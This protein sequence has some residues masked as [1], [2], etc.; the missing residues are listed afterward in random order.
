M[1]ITK[2]SSL[3]KPSLEIVVNMGLDSNIWAPWD[4]SRMTGF[5]RLLKVRET[6]KKNQYSFEVSPSTGLHV[7]GGDNP[8]AIWGTF[9]ALTPGQFLVWWGR[10]NPWRSPVQCAEQ[11][12]HKKM[13]FI[14]SNKKY[15]SAVGIA[16]P[17]PPGAGRD[18]G[19]LER[20]PRFWEKNRNSVVMCAPP[21][22][23]M[24]NEWA[25]L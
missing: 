8:Q 1:L 25:L 4:G 24:F 11:C 23:K 5:N 3:C 7:S 16:L 14:I 6:F 17:P 13:G 21:Q 2:W 10:F 18:G 9:E 19:T 22:A 20:W 12:Y 15:G